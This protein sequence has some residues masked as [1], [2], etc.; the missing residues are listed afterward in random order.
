MSGMDMGDS[1]EMMGTTSDECYATNKAWL[2][3]MAYC[4]QQ[5]CDADGYPAKKQAKCFSNQA[6]AGAS[7]PTFEDS[8]P[9][10]A[11]TVELTGD[12][13]WLNSTNLVNKDL[14]YA[15]HGTLGEFARSEYIH[16]RYSYVLR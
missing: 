1:S 13:V 16:T 12:A 6:V 8:L 3:T 15:T 5:N 2:Q 4:I 7:T 11:P 9:A 14:Y 10:K